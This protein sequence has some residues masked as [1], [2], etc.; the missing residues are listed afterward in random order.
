[1]AINLQRNMRVFYSTQNLA[2]GGSVSS[3][4]P[5]NTWEILILEGSTIDYAPSTVLVDSS[6]TGIVA[7]RSSVS[8]T[9]SLQPVSYSF[10]NYLRTTDSAFMTSDGRIKP[11]A[12]WFMWQ[13]LISNNPV[14]SYESVWTYGGAMLVGEQEA[15]FRSGASTV[16]YAVVP[17]NH[18]YFLLDSVVYQAVNATVDSVAID[19]DI[20]S[21]ATSTWSGQARS[22][23]ELTDSI[24]D[25]AISVFGGMLNNGSFVTANANAGTLS[26]SSSYH[27][28]TKMVSGIEQNNAYIKNRLSEMVITYNGNSYSLPLTAFSFNYNNNNIYLIPETIGIL[29]VAIGAMTGTRAI[30]GSA[31]AY[32]R[33][34]M[35]ELI[36]DM[37][38]STRTS[39]AS[40]ASAIIYIGGNT[41]P[42]VSISMPSVMFSFP[43]IATDEIISVSFNFIA[44]Q[45]GVG[46][47]VV[48]SAAQRSSSDASMLD[49]FTSA[50]SGLWYD[51]RDTNYLYQDSAG[52]VPVTSAGQPVGR[53]V[54][55]T[56]NGNDAIQPQNA[57]RPVYSIRPNVGVR[58]LARGSGAFTNTAYWPSSS[59]SNG[60]TS[61]NLGNGI[62]SDG[63]PYVDIRYAGTPTGTSHTTAYSI[64][65]GNNP[66]SAGD[67]WT[68]HGYAQI[69]AGSLTGV[70]RPIL[71]T[72]EQTAPNTTIVST[73]SADSPVVGGPAVRLVATS[74][75]YTSGNQV[76]VRVTLAF[77]G[78]VPIDI[79]IRWKG[80]QLEKGN[81]PTA[82]QQSLGLYETYEANTY[83]IA[84]VTTD[85]FGDSLYSV[86]NVNFSSTGN[87]GVVTNAIK[88][89]D[90]DT[91]VLVEL[92]ANSEINNGSF[93]ILGSVGSNNWTSYGRG[94]ILSTGNIVSED[95]SAG[96]PLALDVGYVIANDVNNFRANMITGG[97]SNT[98]M[99]TGNFG[100]YP[101]YVFSR[102]DSSL[103]FG[104][105]CSGVYVRNT[106]NNRSGPAYQFIRDIG[107]K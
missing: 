57:K 24:R 3:M 54:D 10:K 86:S 83:S 14:A 63:I 53:V 82:W 100:S 35:S 2:G 76:G 48:I 96:N 19:A 9:T 46:E 55:K 97:S 21:I 40:I 89:N 65:S 8:F 37:L 68:V 101:L 41:Y 11:V 64:A 51:F 60:I 62:D 15:G 74:V 94:T 73:N 90:T 67:I 28:F 5:A 78:T 77:T 84:G 43:E 71:S 29:N 20:S 4:T 66:A 107:I 59:T 103:F 12:D 85:G 88:N 52:T 42:R 99:G 72:S 80:I 39:S 31:T 17:E 49:L 56:G 81:N 69:I 61:T 27:P 33:N 104:G 23:V 32:L 36:K 6:E 1:M 7:D 22:L 38:S 45:T 105:F 98:E 95:Y 70:T 16:N 34:G 47:Q 91:G 106:L 18:I 58:N 102:N 92:S 13:S 93:G 30:T 44:Q 79:T 50:N 87:I 26:A 75:P 25:S